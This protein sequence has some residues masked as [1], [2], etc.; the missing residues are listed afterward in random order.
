M[1]ETEKKIGIHLFS[2]RAHTYLQT[3]TPVNGLNVCASVCVR[4]YGYILLHIATFHIAKGIQTDKVATDV[5][6]H[7]N[8]RPRYSYKS[9]QNK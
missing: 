6:E 4:V 7:T 5:S 3:N 2:H 9:E 8:A 1:N